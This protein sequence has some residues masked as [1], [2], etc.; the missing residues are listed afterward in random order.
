M[1][2]RQYGKELHFYGNNPILTGGVIVKCH[3]HYGWLYEE[4]ILLFMI[5]N[6]SITLI[7][8]NYPSMFHHSY[9]SSQFCSD[10]LISNELDKRF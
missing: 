3:L 1:W 9:V 5:P 7:C 6:N 2:L 8:H 4:I 10:D